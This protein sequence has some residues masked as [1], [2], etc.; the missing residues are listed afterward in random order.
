M[1]LKVKVAESE[2]A[3]SSAL[4]P[5]RV[6]ESPKDTPPGGQYSAVADTSA[7]TGRVGDATHVDGVMGD[8]LTGKRNASTFCCRQLPRCVARNAL[9]RAFEVLG[10]SAATGGDE[11]FRSLVLA[12]IIEPASKLD[13][14]RIRAIGLGVLVSDKI[15]LEFEIS[16]INQ[17]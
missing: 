9:S 7:E 17:A 15:I 1:V 14:L 8:G 2:P 13:S 12:R 6:Q 4:M 3:S 5:L 16:A 10:F 11:V